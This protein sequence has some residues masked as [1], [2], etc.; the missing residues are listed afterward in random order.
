MVQ[1][2][3]VLQPQ[4]RLE[5]VG[6]RHGGQCMGYHIVLHGHIVA[7]GVAEVCAVLHLVDGDVALGLLVQHVGKHQH[8]VV[9][10][11]R[12]EEY[13]LARLRQQAGGE[14][15]VLVDTPPQPPADV[16]A[17]REG[18]LKVVFEV[19]PLTKPCQ[20]GSRV[21]RQLRAVHVEP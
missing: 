7:E 18:A 12:L 3:E 15:R 19:A 21:V 8:P 5:E 14:H 16:D 2:I 20:S 4:C 6:P 11:S 9:D 10:K 13:H 1:Q 17:L